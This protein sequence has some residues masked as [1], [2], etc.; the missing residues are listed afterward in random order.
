MSTLQTEQFAEF[1]DVVASEVCSAAATA[2]E[3]WMAEV[4]FAVTDPRLT[5][6]GRLNAVHEVVAKYRQ[7][8]GKTNP[9]PQRTTLR[10]S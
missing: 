4:E 3:R 5:S 10:A 7:A 1:V 2:V 8:T 9:H 6:L